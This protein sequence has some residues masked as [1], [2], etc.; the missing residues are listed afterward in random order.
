[1]CGIAGIVSRNISLTNRQ[2]IQAATLSLTH[3]GPEDE[4]Y[5]WNDSRTIT[6]GHKRLCIIDVN[7][8]SKQPLHY[9]QRY[10]IVHNG[11]LYNYVE[12]KK[13]LEKKDYSFTTQ[14]DT[15]VIAAAYDAYGTQCLQQFDGMFAF[16]IWDEKEQTLFAA[17]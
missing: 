17:R 12:L 13:E 8:R 10:H 7:P 6:L 14:S 16:A 15:E 1:M 9:Q 4:G 3:R 2:R 11:E 5:W